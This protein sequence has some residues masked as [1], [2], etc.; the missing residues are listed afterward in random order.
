MANLQS[1]IKEEDEMVEKRTED[2]LGEW[3]K[4]KPTKVSVAFCSTS[5]GYFLKTE[6][7]GISDPQYV[8]IFLV[9]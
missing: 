9:F 7:C 1:K 2:V 6:I 5:G 4:S 8:L 3:D